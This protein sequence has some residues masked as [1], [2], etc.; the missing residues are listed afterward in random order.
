MVRPPNVV[1]RGMSDD[2]TGRQG[3]LAMTEGGH[4][5][6]C[7]KQERF[8]M[9]FGLPQKVKQPDA[10]QQRHGKACRPS[11]GW[12]VPA[13]VDAPAPKG[14]TALARTPTASPVSL[15]PGV[16]REIKVTGKPGCQSCAVEFFNG[17]NR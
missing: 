1:I 2:R 8:G 10:L 15:R 4:A 7:L 13:R 12:W 11:N 9:A 5:L 16:L 3:S 17:A 14:R 6:T